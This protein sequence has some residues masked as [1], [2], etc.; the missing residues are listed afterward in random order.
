[1][2]AWNKSLTWGLGGDQIRILDRKVD[3]LLLAAELFDAIAA[4][5]GRP[6]QADDLDKAWR[7]L[8]ASQSHDVG[9]C[10][11]SR[12][13]GDRMAPF[14]RIEDKHNFT[15]GAIGY[16]HLDAAQTR[17]QAVL[18]AALGGLTGRIDTRA[19]AG[20]GLAAV[21]FNPHAWPRTGIAATGRLYPVPPHSRDVVVK[22]R[23]GRVVPSQVAKSDKDP[24]GDLV[25]A[26]VAFQAR[27][28]PSAGYD[29]YA[30]QFS[31]AAVAPAKTDL[32]IDE[33]KL[34]LENE[35]LRVR[36]DPA[37]GGVASLQVK[38]SGRE[39][40]DPAGGPF[41]RFT[42]RPNPLLPTRPNAPA[43]L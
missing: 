23:A 25:M 15:W 8:L 24:A 33:T 27:A 42:G 9:L 14:D 17:G 11:Y 20:G 36:L 7:D 16:N 19:A 30:L 35:F 32:R 18:D 40:L 1:M 26:E 3:A 4:A 10:E 34:V 37:T 12:W 2:D 38:P 13:Q 21:V 5:N 6:S 39:M 28:V 31:P 22:D 29:T 41:P 43:V